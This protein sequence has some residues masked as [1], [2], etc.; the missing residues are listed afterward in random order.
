MSKT[1]HSTGRK[2]TTPTRFGSHASMVIESS[3][4]L[5]P[6]QVLCKDDYGEYVTY[7]D[8]LDNGLADGCRYGRK[9]IT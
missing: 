1:S 6:D 4:P 9:I 7:K 3:L 2:I 8:R 5:L